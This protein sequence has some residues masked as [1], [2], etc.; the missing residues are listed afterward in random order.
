M[1]IKKTVAISGM[2]CASCSLTIERTLKKMEG[3]ESAEVSY[4]T[5]KAKIQFDESKIDV[6]KC[7]KRWI[8]SD[9]NL[10]MRN[11]PR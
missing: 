11:L 5:E 2:H 7:R 3:V 9:T 8:H 1:S 4:G 6:E 10:W